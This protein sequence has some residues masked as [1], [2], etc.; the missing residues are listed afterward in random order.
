MA[1][2]GKL[3]GFL[4]RW[5]IARAEVRQTKEARRDERHAEELQMA[6][7]GATNRFPPMGG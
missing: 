5:R 1:T 7:D 4:R 3:T 6:R 2:K